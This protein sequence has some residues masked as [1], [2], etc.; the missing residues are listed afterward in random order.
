M[1]ARL[2]A[3]CLQVVNDHTDVVH[4]GF[5]P[6]AMALVSVPPPWWA[7][8]IGALAWLL[9]TALP[10]GV[11]R[12]LVAALLPLGADGGAWTLAPRD[13]VAL[14]YWRVESSSSA[15]A[16]SASQSAAAMA[17]S[18]PSASSSMISPASSHGAIGHHHHHHH[19]I[20]GVEGPQHHHHP[21]P[22]PSSTTTA[23]PASS[24]TAGMGG[25]GDHDNGND[26]DDHDNSSAAPGAS[27]AA[28]HGS[29]HHSHHH[30]Q[31]PH[32]QHPHM[33]GGGGGRGYMYGG[34]GGSGSGGGSGGEGSYT[35]CLD[36]VAD[37][38]SLGIRCVAPAATGGA[39]CVRGR[40]HM[41]FEVGRWQWRIAFDRSIRTS[42]SIRASER[43]SERDMDESVNQ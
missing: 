35:I 31:H 20:I 38:D 41:A 18:V 22:L 13:F 37:D 27:G 17:Q 40:L 33:H 16:S 14:R 11:G 36:S 24:G 8:P 15:A 30:A 5:R 3:V 21:H 19:G 6:A 1:P 34:G 39:D 28:H 29:L 23:L 32:A 4:L 42:Q 7:R 25:G 2:S 43:A 10:L 12:A 9:T 26:N